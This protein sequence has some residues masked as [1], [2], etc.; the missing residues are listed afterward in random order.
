MTS[1][2]R[3]F[4][5]IG[6]VGVAL[7]RPVFAADAPKFQIDPSWLKTLGLSER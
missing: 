3:T 4:A 5:L 6:L 7:V 1:L 2:V